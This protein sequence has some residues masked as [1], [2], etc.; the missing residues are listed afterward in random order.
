MELSKKLVAIPSVFGREWEIGEFIASYFEDEGL[1]RQ[2]VPGFPPNIIIRHEVD[3]SRPTILLNG[4]M[5]P[6]EP[7]FEW[8]N[9]PFSATMKEGR[10]YGLG[11]SDMKGGLA[12]LMDAFRSV[13]S[14]RSNIILSIVVDEEGVSTGAFKLLDKVNA[15]VALVTEPTNEKTV[16][17]SRG[18]CALNIELFG[19]KTHGSRPEEGVNAVAEMAR[20]LHCLDEIELGSHEKLGKASLAPLK[21]RGGTDSLSVPDY[22]RLLVDRHIVPGEGKEEIKEDFKT[23]IGSLGLRSR[24]RISWMRRST[25]FLEPYVLS[26]GNEQVSRFAEVHEEHFGRQPEFHYASGPGDY[27]V[28]ATRMPTLVFGPK[29]GNWH[30]PDEYV[31]TESL[32]RCR[33]FYVH[34]LESM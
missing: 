12:V 2:K 25:P 10:L 8:T 22:C 9:G 31:E 5:D 3:D 30:R 7:S 24:V 19:K 20:V 32:I 4:H 15:D 23:K 14:P 29:G 26:K 1:E 33:D 27:N 13:Q 18:R 21:I 16:L 11:A 17:G 28:F 34:L 6:V